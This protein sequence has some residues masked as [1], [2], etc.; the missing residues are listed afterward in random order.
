MFLGLYQAV[1]FLYFFVSFRLR[2]SLNVNRHFFVI[3]KSFLNTVSNLL[4]D[5]LLPP[6]MHLTG[7]ANY[8]RKMTLE[9]FEKSY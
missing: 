8:T 9:N 1:R 6:K 7:R 2:L 3:P 4:F 5:L